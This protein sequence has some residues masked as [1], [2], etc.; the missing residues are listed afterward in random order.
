M[1]THNF[2]ENGTLGELI[3]LMFEPTQAELHGESWHHF[4]LKDRLEDLMVMCGRFKSKGD[5]RKNGYGGEIPW[6][7]NEMKIGKGKN[8]TTI[9]IYKGT[10]CA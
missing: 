5:A 9:Y 8:L 3:E 2:I 6:G 10:K 1:A 7:F 4:A